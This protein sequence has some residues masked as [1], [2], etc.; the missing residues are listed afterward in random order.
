M[1]NDVKSIISLLIKY[2]IISKFPLCNISAG[3]F[4]INNNFNDIKMHTIRA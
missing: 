4:E 3:A 2:N 1:S